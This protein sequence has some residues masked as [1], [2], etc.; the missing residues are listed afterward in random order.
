MEFLTWHDGMWRCLENDVTQTA[1]K[2]E[3]M[4]RLIKTERK[5]IFRALLTSLTLLTL[6]KCLPLKQASA[7]SN[8]AEKWAIH[9]GGSMVSVPF[10]NVSG[11][12]FDLST[13]EFTSGISKMAM[14]SALGKLKN[15]VYGSFCSKL[16]LIEGKRFS[17]ALLPRYKALFLWLMI[18]E[19]AI[20]AKPTLSS[21]NRVSYLCP[22]VKPMPSS[23]E[24]F[25][26]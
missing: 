5:V 13:N 21:S 7:R 6:T 22:G 26:N 11:N 9:R 18:W 25:G 8:H 1:N 15:C 10:T 3:M 19:S 23:R 12:K 20:T 17:A 24:L 4:E 2:L 16:P 14:Y